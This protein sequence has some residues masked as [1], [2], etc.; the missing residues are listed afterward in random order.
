MLVALSVDRL[1]CGPQDFFFCTGFETILLKQRKKLIDQEKI[2][3]RLFYTFSLSIAKIF[4]LNTSFEE[5]PHS[6]SKPVA[7]YR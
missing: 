4:R 1:Q 2:R 6:Y 5:F 3:N 7:L